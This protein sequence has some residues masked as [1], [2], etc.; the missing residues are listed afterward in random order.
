LTTQG[1]RYTKIDVVAADDG[2]K[3]DIGGQDLSS[4]NAVIIVAKSTGT[5]TAGKLKIRSSVGN[6]S[7]CSFDTSAT[8]NQ[9]VG[10]AGDEARFYE[11]KVDGATNVSH[12]GTFDPSSVTELEVTGD[13]LGTDLSVY[14]VYFVTGI[15]QAIGYE[16]GIQQTCVD[17]MTREVSR[18]MSDILCNQVANSSI[19]SSDSYLINT[20]FKRQDL[21]VTAMSTGDILIEREVTVVKKYN[22]P[23]AITSNTATYPS[24]FKISKVIVGETPLDVYYRASDVPTNAYHDDGAGTLTFNGLSDGTKITIF[25]EDTTTFSATVFKA[26]EQ[27]FYGYLSVPQVSENGVVSYL[28]A[29]K[30]QINFVSSSQADDGSTV[31]IQFKL[32][33]DSDGVYVTEA[34]QV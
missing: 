7:V 21:K 27:G 9:W 16:L 33:A 23:I 31:E 10:G 29:K 32:F 20:T 34:K 14:E 25:Y 1:Q 18:E 12:T 15:Q 22:T 8:A 24:N 19:S 17:S 30:A 2:A 11:F 4:Y 13:T 5:S 6:E 28:V 3:L 26:L